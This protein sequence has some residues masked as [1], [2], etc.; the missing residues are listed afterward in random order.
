MEYFGITTGSRVSL[1]QTI[2][3]PFFIT[4]RRIIALDRR[5]NIQM[6]NKV[7]IMEENASPCQTTLRS[8]YSRNIVP[9]ENSRELIG[10]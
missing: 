3:K 9:N 5:R 6:N 8:E 10:E 4:S 7:V 1:F 2:R